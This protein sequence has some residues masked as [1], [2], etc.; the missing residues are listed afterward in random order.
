M[1]EQGGL[2]EEQ[3]ARAALNRQRALKLREQKRKLSLDLKPDITLADPG[4]SGG[5]V[6]T[7]HESPATDCQFKRP[8]CLQQEAPS[9]SKATRI[10]GSC[11]ECLSDSAPL[12]A[13]LFEAFNIKVC[14]VCRETRD[15][16]ELVSKTEAQMR[17]LVPDGTLRVLRYTEKAN[18]RQSS[19]APLKLYLVRDVRAKSHAR[20]GGEKGLEAERAKRE[21]RKWSGALK[22]TQGAFA[23][24]P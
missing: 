7:S 2:T 11:Q 22:R 5:F 8:R 14:H 18:P 12:V 3:R 9:K 1:A 20:F 23:R 15:E 21:E 16:Y 10:E 6:S 13:N 24:A 4:A 17:Y 19:W